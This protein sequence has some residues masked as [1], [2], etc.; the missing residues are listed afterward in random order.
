MHAR[1]SRSTRSGT[2]AASHMPTIP[3]S[4]RPQNE[5]RSSPAA[6]AAAS[7]ARAKPSIVRGPT[8]ASPCP[9]WS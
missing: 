3:P 7:A 2:F 8:G 9:G 6:S 5:K 4:E 1:T